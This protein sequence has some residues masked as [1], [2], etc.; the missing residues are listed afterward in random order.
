[1]RIGEYV[2]VSSTRTG[3]L[4]CR[5]GMLYR[6]SR[7]SLD[8]T[9][10]RAEAVMAALGKAVQP[11]SNVLVP[12]LVEE[13]DAWYAAVPFRPEVF[14]GLPR[15]YLRCLPEDARRHMILLAVAAMDVLA[16]EG[17]VHGSL[18]PDC[19]RITVT[20]SGV[21]CIVLEDLR[22]VG[23]G[24]FEPL[25]IDAES[26]YAAPEVRR[27]GKPTAA[28]DAFSLALCLHEWLAGELPR[29]R[30]NGPDLT[31]DS[32]WLSAA[33]PVWARGVLADL[34]NANAAS[35]PELSEALARLA[36]GDEAATVAIYS[37]DSD[38]EE[39][40]DIRTLLLE[41]DPKLAR[42]YAE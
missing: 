39:D 11:G 29:C 21:L 23:C 28:S 7:C 19:F 9:Q 31:K 37:C 34:L 8:M 13:D 5:N 38:A 3:Y 1:M 26:S 25:E 24:R 14:Q 17:V 16:R 2:V 4:A 30:G 12:D 36:K 22:N 15:A 27:G 41:E 32:V 10:P 6:V 40:A 18:T 20:D 35:R 33:V 42:R